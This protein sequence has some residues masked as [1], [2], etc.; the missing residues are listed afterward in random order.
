MRSLY[1]NKK[2]V[3]FLEMRFPFKGII[4]LWLSVSTQCLHTMAFSVLLERR[5]LCHNEMS[6]LPPSCTFESEVM[7]LISSKYSW[8]LKIKCFYWFFKYAKVSI[9]SQFFMDFPVFMEI[10]LLTLNMSFSFICKFA[11]ICIIM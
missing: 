2:C 1:L 3:L 7:K 10:K 6:F 5:D 4:C 9:L 11:E 8:V